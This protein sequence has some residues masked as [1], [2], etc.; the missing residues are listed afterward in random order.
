VNISDIEID[1]FG[2]WRG[3]RLSGFSDQLTVIYGPNE[4]GKTTLLQFVRAMLYGFSPERRARY[5]PPVAGGD[6]GG[7]LQ[8]RTVVGPLVVTRREQA[9]GEDDAIISARPGGPPSGRSLI[10]L[11]GGIDEPT[12]NHVF[13]IG[14]REIQ[15]LGTLTDSQAAHWLYDLT[16]GVDHV[17]LADVME[18]LETWRGRIISPEHHDL[19]HFHTE[20][21][22]LAFLDHQTAAEQAHGHDHHPSHDR[23][24]PF[25]RPGIAERR[26]QAQKL[27]ARRQQLKAEIDGLRELTVRYFESAETGRRLNSGIEGLQQADAA[28]ERRQWLASMARSL[29]DK[30]HARASLGQQLAALGNVQPL[31]DGSLERFQELQNREQAYAARVQKLRARRAQLRRD[32][33]AVDVNETLCRHAPR[34]EALGEQQQWMNFLGEQARSLDEQIAAIELERE[35]EHKRWLEIVGKR[36]DRNLPA[37]TPRQFD[38]LQSAARQLAAHRTTLRES[39]AAADQHHRT[40]K[41]AKGNMTQALGERA[42]E[43]I[44]ELVAKGGET[45]SRLRRRVQ[46]EERLDVILRKLRELEAHSQEWLSRQMLPGWVLV[47]LG[48]MF[49]I[50]FVFL[51]AGAMALFGIFSASVLGGSSMPLSLMFL[52]VVFAAVAGVTK[53]HLENYSSQQLLTANN[54]IRALQHERKDLTEERDSLDALLPRGGG[55]LVA[56]LQAAEKELAELEKAL[57]LH[58]HAESVKRNAADAK[59]RHGAIR[60]AHHEAR[61]RWRKALREAGLPDTVKPRHVQHFRRHVRQAQA[62]A[63][64]LEELRGQAQERRKAHDALTQRIAQI[65]ADVGWKGAT[66][67][68]VA[69]LREMTAEMNAQR[70]KFER[71]EALLGE[72]RGAHRRLGRCVRRLARARA[73]RERHLADLRLES[74]A[75]LEWRIEQLREIDRLRSEIAALT[76]DITTALHGRAVEADLKAILDGDASPAHLEKEITQE[77]A[78]NRARLEQL[79]EQRGQVREQLKSLAAD[80]RLAE[81]QVELASVE[82]RLERSL[83]RWRTLALSS[84]VLESVREVYE[85][86]RQPAALREASIYLSRLTG[87][88]YRRVWTPLGH[89]VLR[90]DDANGKP[91]PVEVLSRGARE[92]LFLSLRLAIIRAYAEQGIRLPLVLD[93]VLVNFDLKRARAAAILLREFAQDNHQVLVFTCHEH[94]AELFRSLKADVRQLPDRN[95]DSPGEWVE[96]AV[97]PEP[98]PP[99]R[100]SNPEP[101]LEPPTAVPEPSTPV[102]IEPPLRQAVSLPLEESAP[103]MVEPAPEPRRAVR[104]PVR[105]RA[106]PN[107]SVV[108][109]PA[110]QRRRRASVRLE[111][112]SGEEF[113]GELTDRVNNGVTFDEIIGPQLVAPLDEPRGLND[114]GSRLFPPDE[115]LTPQIEFE[116]NGEAH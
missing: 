48:A 84:Q 115:E 74:P 43:D 100:L 10:E 13:A 42:D 31:P 40:A 9:D 28:L 68:P 37:T 44:G 15:Q 78:A 6:A 77:R 14:L 7:R 98:E 90:V 93:D 38:N 56:R 107:Q 86:E 29:A 64:Q 20:E 41:D 51:L 62:G 67:D 39:R 18:R 32:G 71:R 16:L 108:P 23:A 101:E 53:Y 106:K 22:R 95:A 116:D 33:E 8:L 12:F 61:Q 66:T 50:G 45:V 99:I 27:L 52:G 91:L 69:K 76:G 96:A 104:I 59:Q 11:L 97:D 88:R 4:A 25:D 89:R 19:E 92:Q 73:A 34:L 49:V 47:G 110:R 109:P 54:Q 30:W 113:E 2:V 81:R 82:T 79:F 60:Q 36:G 105:S 3:L 83:E 103:V 5:L 102:A 70:T 55:P 21:E 87:G 24:A 17:S 112:W 80:T 26:A 35:A 114:L 1:G 57:P 58:G 63:K 65:A 72:A 85:R 94:I 75:E 46:I 111:R